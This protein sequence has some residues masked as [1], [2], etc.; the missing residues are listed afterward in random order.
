[1]ELTKAQKQ[2]VETTKPRVIVI[3]TAASGKT[4]CLSERVK[5]LLSQGIPANEIVAITFT[6]AAAEEI[7]ERVGNPQ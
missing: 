5:W 6:N 7:S 4:R 3:A 2:I 1:M